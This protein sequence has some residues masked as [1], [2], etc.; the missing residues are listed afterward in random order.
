[1]RP[2]EEHASSLPT[3]R[4]RNEI[5]INGDLLVRF[6]RSDEGHEASALIGLGVKPEMIRPVAEGDERKSTRG[7]FFVPDSSPAHALAVLTQIQEQGAV[8]RSEI[9]HPTTLHDLRALKLISTDENDD[10]VLSNPSRLADPKFLLQR[11]VSAME[12]IKVARTVLLFNPDAGATEISDAVSL[13]LGKV[14]E[15]RA[16]KL[17][18]GNAIR[19]WTV[20]L[21]PYLLNPDS[22]S[23]AAA[24]V[25]YSR[26]KKVTKGRPSSLRKALAKDLR[27]LVGEGKTPAE[28]ADIFNL[29]RQT[30]YQWKKRARLK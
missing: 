28:I 15:L 10:I 20:W 17:R 23:E 1:V 30:I 9:L 24:Q 22:S 19:R 26:A 7:K 14:W 29:S 4:S 18:N 27:R 3:G 21:E 25:A 5:D 2:S 6:L 11:G 8:A 16:T 13:E 12:C